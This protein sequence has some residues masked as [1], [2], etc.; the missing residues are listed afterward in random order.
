MLVKNTRLEE[1]KITAASFKAPF[2]W[3]LLGIY[4]CVQ[5]LITQ[6]LLPSGHYLGQEM[7]VP[8]MAGLLVVCG[9]WACFSHFRAQGLTALQ[10]QLQDLQAKRNALEKHNAK[11]QELVM[12]DA[13][14][15]VSN[16]R[17]FDYL[18]AREWQLGIRETRSLGL[19]VCDIDFFKQFNDQFGHLAGD[20]CLVAVAQTLKACLANHGYEVARYGGEEFVVLLPGAD[21]TETQ[22][23]AEQLK[24]AVHA[25]PLSPIAHATPVNVTLSLGAS[26]LLPQQKRK[27]QDLLSSADQALYR[28][29]AAGRNRVCTSELV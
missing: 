13:L 14:T 5:A 24:Q 12:T 2:V 8:L 25:L 19:I 18:L 6:L 4:A 28:A 23:V 26:C 22:K 9:A 3:P 10:N 29:K 27:S 17:Y 1:V 16:R 7:G 11:L 21:L 15:G 20:D